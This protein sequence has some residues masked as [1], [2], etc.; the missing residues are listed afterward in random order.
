M[1]QNPEAWAKEDLLIEVGLGATKHVGSDAYPYYI[2]EILP[3]GVIGLYSPGSHFDKDHPWEGGSMVV[4]KFDPQHKSEFY[5]RRRYGKWWKCDA[6]GK[7][8]KKTDYQNYGTIH[9][10]F[11]HACSYQDPSF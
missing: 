5:I 11:G 9:L 3:K 4:D 1:R 2:S 7:T 10:R 6:T 8:Y